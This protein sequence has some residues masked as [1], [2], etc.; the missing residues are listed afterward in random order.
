MDTMNTQGIG[1]K[2]YTKPAGIIYTCSHCGAEIQQ[3]LEDVQTNY[4]KFGDNQYIKDVFDVP[5]I[6][7]CPECNGVD[8]LVD[9][10]FDYECED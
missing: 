5:Y 2:I 10:K 7:E 9:W 8:K 1:F 6:V 4:G 3:P